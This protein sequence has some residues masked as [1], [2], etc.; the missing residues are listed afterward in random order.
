MSKFKKIFYILLIMIVYMIL[1][2]IQISPKIIFKGKVKNIPVKDRV[3]IYSGENIRIS[4]IDDRYTGIISPNVIEVPPGTHEIKAEYK[5]GRKR[6]EHYFEPYNYPAGTKVIVIAEK[7]DND[8]KVEFDLKLGEVS[9]ETIN[10][11]E[12]IFYIISTLILLTSVLVFVSQ[13]EAIRAL[14]KKIKDGEGAQLKTSEDL[15][16]STVNGRKVYVDN[17]NVNFGKYTLNI[18]YNK[19]Q[20]DNFFSKKKYMFFNNVEVEVE[21]YDILVIG[22]LIEN[23]NKMRL[24]FKLNQE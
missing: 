7:S 9:E 16:I 11:L 4:K 10:I 24:D 18:V 3:Y 1:I 8:G 21:K 12:Y 14:E 13:I 5:K 22:Y 6:G 19:K 17:L 20:E 15:Y 2:F 23:N